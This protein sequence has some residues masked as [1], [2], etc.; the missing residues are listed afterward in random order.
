MAVADPRQATKGMTTR[1]HTVWK[2]WQPVV[3]LAIAVGLS[4]LGMAF[5]TV[6][7]FGYGGL[8]APSSGMI[9]VVGVQL[10]LYAAW[11]WSRARG[12]EI[13]LTVTA[14]FQ[15]VGGAIISVLPLPILPFEPDQSLHHYVSHVVF[16]VAQLPLIVVPLRTLRP[17][18]VQ[19]VHPIPQRKEPVG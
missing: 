11:L 6:R 13:A 3:W 12:L 15:L 9:P 14:L 17:G 4:A 10:A 1:A 16:G 18:K 8:W 19:I 2:S 5:H 7:E